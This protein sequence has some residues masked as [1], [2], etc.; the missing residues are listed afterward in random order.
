MRALSI[1]V[2]MGLTAVAAADGMRLQEQLR[3]AE[4]AEKDGIETKD[5]EAFERCALAYV[6]AARIAETE[7]PHHAPMGLYN[8]GVCFEHARSV[9]AALAMYGQLER[10]YPR[11]Q[12]AQR[13]QARRANIYLRIGWYAEAAQELEAYARRWPG[14]DEASDA[15]E[16]AL[17][18]R[19]ALG[20]EAAAR[21]NGER[22]IA[23]FG[24]KRPR[25]AGEIALWLA[26]HTREHG[27]LD[28]GVRA[29][30]D[31]LKR[32][33]GRADRHVVAGAYVALGRLQWDA[34]CKAKGSPARGLC[35][36]AR[37]RDPE[38]R[39]SAAPPAVAT[40]D[41]AL[42][43]DAHAT[44]VQAVRVAQ[45]SGDEH[46]RLIADMA[47][48]LLADA[49]LE[50]ALAVEMPAPSVAS[51]GALT[52]A[53]QKAIASWL[54]EW[55]RELADAR[56]AYEE[57]LRSPNV[58][59][60][61]QAAGRIAWLT[62][63]AADTLA[64]ARLPAWKKPRLDELRGAYCDALQDAAAP[65]E[66]TAQAAAEACLARAA[67]TGVVEEA[68]LCVAVHDRHHPASAAAGERL[69]AVAAPRVVDV[70]PEVRHWPPGLPRA[71]TPSPP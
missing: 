52:P 9:T 29:Y 20:D 36:A 16:N 54:A 57:L 31:W 48:L 37:R 13:A 21:K 38:P 53:G 1:V 39:C 67:K 7:A 4:A 59:V 66:Q 44:L 2:V 69:P 15:L 56:R 32:F 43:G 8:A 50:A 62:Q 47:R 30:R 60:S 55:Q 65:L 3:V 19:A 26:D 5:P 35:L 63:H 27:T 17:R 10:A 70:E 14:G 40:R 34:S 49:R 61:V 18:L 51:G 71:I 33:G 45:A 6:E 41:A 46:A 68:A 64:S 23:L 28:G 58:R 42:A 22:W 24:G 12:L 25:E 11:D